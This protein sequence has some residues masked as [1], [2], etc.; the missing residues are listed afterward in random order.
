MARN[1]RDKDWF[2]GNA[3]GASIPD[4]TYR[5]QW[6]SQVLIALDG[7]PNL[8]KDAATGIYSY[9]LGNDTIFKRTIEINTVVAGVEKKVVTNVTWV[10]RGGAAKSVSAESHLFNWK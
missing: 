6:D 8:K 9:D 3:F 2:L 1:L 4:G 10:E 5:V 7:N